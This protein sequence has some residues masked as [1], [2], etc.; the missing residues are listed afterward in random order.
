MGYYGMI[1]Y[2]AYS[3]LMYY[4]ALTEWLIIATAMANVVLYTVGLLVMI[5]RSMKWR[6]TREKR[7]RWL[8]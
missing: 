8:A 3:E 4:L 7:G 5:A 6:T 2:I 1:S